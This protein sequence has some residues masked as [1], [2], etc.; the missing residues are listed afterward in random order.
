MVTKLRILHLVAG[1]LVGATQ[2]SC[3]SLAHDFVQAKT[4]IDVGPEV[5]L[6]TN[7][8]LLADSACK[9]NGLGGPP[10]VRNEN[11]DVCPIQGMGT[12]NWREV[13]RI[14]KQ[15]YLGAPYV[16]GRLQ[17]R[18][19]PREPREDETVG[20]P[21]PMARV[22]VDSISLAARLDAEIDR[23]FGL[24]AVAKLAK[25]GI[26][27]NAEAQARFRD[28]LRR[29]VKEKINVE[30][31]WFVATYTGGR[32]AIEADDALSA[33]R[34][35]VQ[36][37]EGAQYVTGVAGF[38]VLSNVADISINST[39]TLAA[40]LTGVVEDPTRAIEEAS[41]GGAWEKTVANVIRVNAAIRAETQTI[42]P[43]WV[44]V[45]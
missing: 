29:L 28:G 12:A 9:P 37:S 2:L 24:E 13:A 32:A 25:A 45:E 20:G 22:A 27:V 30:L 35:E 16:R 7:G 15:H 6:C 8:V 26:P 40:A 10:W 14:V 41:L 4:G 38:A 21:P 36:A 17:P 39:Q 34:H 42:Y 33:C 19:K 3:S 18:C 1:V 11:F 44:Q 23:H 43:L 5:P 31:V